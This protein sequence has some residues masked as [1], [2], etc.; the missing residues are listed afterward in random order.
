MSAPDDVEGSAR[1]AIDRL[2]AAMQ[3]VAR[4]DVRA[5]KALYSHADDA[6]AFFGWGGW[7]RGWEAVSRR[8]DW[9]G[10][11]FKGG[12]PVTYRTL[13]TIVTPVLLL[14]TE[15]ETFRTRLE[16]LAGETAWSNRVTHVFRREQ[17]E[18]RL[19]HRHANRLEER[20]VPATRL[21]P[22]SG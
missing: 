3:D 9:A 20:Y 4:G 11:Q 12:G 10:A 16:G 2:H 8:W 17:G 7:E 22:T 18:W 21:G 1:A 5:I 6:T 13:T 19:V 14:V 15:I